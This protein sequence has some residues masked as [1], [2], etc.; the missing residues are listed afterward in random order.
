MNKGLIHQIIGPI[1]D[2]KFDP[3]ELPKLNNA[4]EIDANGRRVVAEV[5]Q[6]MGDDVVRCVALSSTDG[7]VC[8]I[9]ILRTGLGISAWVVMNKYH[10][11]GISPHRS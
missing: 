8:R 7:L 11:C 6:H 1:V 2:V 5:A 4:I 10:R 3:G 9:Y